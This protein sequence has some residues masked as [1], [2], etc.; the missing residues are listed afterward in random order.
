MAGE[1]IKMGVG[2]RT[3]PKVVR[4]A[5]MLKADRLR[6]VGGLHAVWG[7]FDT[8]SVEGHLDGYTAEVMDADLGWKGFTAAMVA[9]GWLTDTGDGLAAPDYEEHNGPVAKRRAMETSRKGRSRNKSADCPHETDDD[10]GQVSA[11]DADKVRNREDKR[12]EEEPPIAP[13]GA[14]EGDGG[15]KHGPTIPCPYDRIVGLY[16]EVLPGLPKAKLMPASRQKALRKVWGWVLSSTKGDGQRRATTTDE[17]LHWLRGYFERAQV[18]DFLMGRTPRSAE[19]AN[20]Q[21]DLDFLLTD[22]GMK[23]VIEKTQ[24]AA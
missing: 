21:C 19:H 8:H 9:I 14:A 3:H 12:R 20:W 5:T 7:L 6:V 4:M 15:D 24:D 1:W 10:S 18:N 22:K 2:L 11:S 13:K 23:Q 17:A 16:H